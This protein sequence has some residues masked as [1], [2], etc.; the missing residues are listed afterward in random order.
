MRPK[1][2][3]DLEKKEKESAIILILL[4]LFLVI[5]IGRYFLIKKRGNK[6]SNNRHKRVS[7]AEKSRGRLSLFLNKKVFGIKE[8]VL[9]GVMADS[10]NRRITSIDLVVKYDDRVLDF[11]RVD[12]LLPQFALFTHKK[13][14][15]E[16]I[17]TLVK[18]LEA[19][20][21]FIFKKRRIVSLIFLP[22]K[23]GET[24]I[25]LLQESGKDK[26]QMVDQSSKN[27]LTTFV[28][29]VKLVVR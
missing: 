19:D 5:F 24:R 13:T 4:S 14:N 3:K 9:I 27:I 20:K 23:K 7:T 1:N 21:S 11:N 15:N 28:E 17:L 12:N 22:K 6:L 8:P 25:Y 29:K 2:K 16:L 10:A 26:T 18:K